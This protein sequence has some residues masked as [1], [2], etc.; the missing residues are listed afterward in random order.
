MGTNQEWVA[1]TGAASG[2]GAACCALL[3]RKG[4]R[5]VGLDRNEPPADSVDEFISYDQGDRGAV[6]SAARQ[7]PEGFSGLMNVAGVAPS[8]R[9]SAADILR[10]NFYGARHLTERVLPKLAAGAAV[11]N[12]SSGTA[13]GW[14]SN[15]E[16]LKTLLSVSVEDDLDS[17]TAE[18][19]L[20]PGGLGNLAAYPVS[21][22]LLSVWTMQCAG[23]W[24]DRQLRINAVAP[25]AVTTPIVDEF[26]TS[27]GDEAA[28]RLQ[29]FGAASPEVIASA[30]VFLLEDGARWVNGAVLPVD[31]GAI[32][33]GTMH[34]LGLA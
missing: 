30:S 16:L 14:P 1:V 32:A 9:F 22:Q 5:V 13:A 10:I 8:A 15:L 23:A 19:G 24:R 21:K 6:E 28:K 12:M 4:R 3:K 29:S 27:F 7:L 34:N 26:L 25:A 2:I 17:V 20:T 11:V 18:H 33:A 31:N